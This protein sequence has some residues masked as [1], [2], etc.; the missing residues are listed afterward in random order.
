MRLIANSKNENIEIEKRLY[1]FKHIRY[2][3]L[4]KNFHF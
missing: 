4:Y 2:D 1:S 3:I